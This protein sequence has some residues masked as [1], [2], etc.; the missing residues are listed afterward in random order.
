MHHP[1]TPSPEFK[2]NLNWAIW[3][4]QNFRVKYPRAS[5]FVNKIYGISHDQPP[6]WLAAGAQRWV[7]YRKVV[8]VWYDWERNGHM[9]LRI[10]EV[11]NT[12]I[13]DFKNFVEKRLFNSD[14][15]YRRG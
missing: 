15:Y 11:L 12:R 14:F 4:Y 9:D 7:K 6:T 1:C 10:P 5:N 2:Y 3:V 8:K 13:V